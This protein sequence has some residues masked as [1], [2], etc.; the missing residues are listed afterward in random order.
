M[1]ATLKSAAKP[2][3]ARKPVET[4]DLVAR[5]KELTKQYKRIVPGSIQREIKGKLAGKLSVEIR[6]A[7][8]GCPNVRRVA[9]SDLHQVKFCED[10]TRERR[11]KARRKIGAKAVKY[12]K[13]AVS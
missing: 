2:V 10:C 9:T 5:E 1:T 13:D 3:V 7:T 4:I 11:N 8:K 12:A 6:C